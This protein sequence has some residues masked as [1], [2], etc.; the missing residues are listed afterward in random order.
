MILL[1]WG[2][3][4]LC[5]K[6][7][8][9]KYI[10]VCIIPVLNVSGI[11]SVLFL[12]PQKWSAFNLLQLLGIKIVH[13]LTIHTGRHH[14]GG[15]GY[16]SWETGTFDCLR[17]F[18]NLV[19]VAAAMGG[20]HLA[21]ACLHMHWETEGDTETGCSHRLASIIEHI[22]IVTFLFMTFFQ[23]SWLKPCAGETFRGSFV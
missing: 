3:W 9:N 4:L 10:S 5:P 17:S 8:P 12:F 15:A 7:G 23:T 1:I 20:N 6:F 2:F 19:L 13:K 21:R 22:S 16:L 14:A 11:F 18:F